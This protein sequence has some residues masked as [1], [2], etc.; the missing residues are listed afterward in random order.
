MTN[1]DHTSLINGGLVRRYS[2]LRLAQ[3]AAAHQRYPNVI[4]LLGCDERYW[5]PATPRLA[6][7]LMKAG[8]E[9]AEVF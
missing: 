8:H 6:A 5:V 9:V 2:T 7:R 3:Q 4:I 1:K